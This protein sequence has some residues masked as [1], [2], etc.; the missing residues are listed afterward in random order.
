MAQSIKKT[1]EILKYC[2]DYRMKFEKM[3]A[4]GFIGSVISKSKAGGVTKNGKTPNYN[5]WVTIKKKAYFNMIAHKDGDITYGQ[6]LKRYEQKLPL[7]DGQKEMIS[8]LGKFQNS[9]F[10]PRDIS[11]YMNLPAPYPEQ[12]IEA[13]ELRKVFIK[14]KV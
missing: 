14:M 10:S 5:N 4:T 1:K 3:T 11:H 9:D 6:E 12:F 13:N 2:K 7:C 8:E